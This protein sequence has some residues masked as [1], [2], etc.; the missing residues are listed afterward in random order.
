MSPLLFKGTCNRVIFTQWL[1]YLLQNLPKDAQGKT[2]RH[3]GDVIDELIKRYHC[4]LMYLPAYSPDFNPIEKAWSVLKAKVRKF[5]GNNNCTI[6]EAINY[7][8]SQM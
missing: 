5:M 4:R 2:K 3:K 1:A 6:E 7:G 8:F